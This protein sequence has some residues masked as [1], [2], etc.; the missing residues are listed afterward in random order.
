MFFTI[1][2]PFSPSRHPPAHPVSVPILHPRDTSSV[3]TNLVTEVR[4]HRAYHVEID[5]RIPH[6]ILG[7]KIA[8]YTKASEP[9]DSQD[10]AVRV[11]F[12]SE[13]EKGH[14]LP[15]TAQLE[16]TNGAKRSETSWASVEARA[17]MGVHLDCQRISFG[18]PIPHPKLNPA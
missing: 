4:M 8:T 17:T 16:E 13:P 5:Q 10:A 18:H 7:T 6:T 9:G 12:L 14:T 15:K 1:S 11:L 2:R 3:V